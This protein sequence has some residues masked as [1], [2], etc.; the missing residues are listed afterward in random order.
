[1]QNV[2]PPSNP[3]TDLSASQVNLAFWQ[4]SGAGRTVPMA[5]I[6]FDG[7]TPALLMQRLAFDPNQLLPNIAFVKNGT[8]DYDFTFASTYQDEKGEARAFQPAAAMASTQGAAAGVKANAS[9]PG[10]SQT[11]NVQVLD[12]ADLNVDATFL[13]VVW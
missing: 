10:G 7:V 6:L 8:G 13:L 3:K 4:L 2:R 1:M 5:I 11:V 12:A 9:N